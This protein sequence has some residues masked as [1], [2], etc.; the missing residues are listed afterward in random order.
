M[1]ALDL[2]KLEPAR[3]LGR[4]PRPARRDHGGPL[5]VDWTS[6]RYLS[7][8]HRLLLILGKP[9]SSPQDINSNRQLSESMQK[10]VA[11]TS[12]G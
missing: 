9:T 11:T 3:H 5:A 2:L 7:R 10:I 6:G 4:L 8:N 1:A 12:A